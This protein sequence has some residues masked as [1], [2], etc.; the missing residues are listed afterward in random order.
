MES[1]QKEVY[2]AAAR[3]II[4]SVLDGFNGTVFAYG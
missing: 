3:P 4:A 2:D 1:E